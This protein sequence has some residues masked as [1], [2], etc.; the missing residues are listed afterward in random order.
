MKFDHLQTFCALVE[1]GSL[2]EAARRVHRTQPAISQHLRALESEFGL[3]LYERRAGRPTP[4]GATLYRRAKDLLHRGNDLRREMRAYDEGL[5]PLIV[6]ASDTNALYV[7]PEYIQ[8]F[9]K[10]HA[11][12]PLSIVCRPSAAIA[13]AV[14]NGEIDVGIVTLPVNTESL[15]HHRLDEHRLVLI[16]PKRH[17]L[18]VHK[19]ARATRLANETFVLLEPDTRTGTAIEAFLAHH[20]IAPAIAMRTG[21]FEVIKRYVAEGV[22]ISFVPERVLTKSDRNALAVVSVPGLPAIPIGAVWRATGYRPAG[23]ARFLNELGVKTA[24]T[25][26]DSPS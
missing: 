9:R 2:D 24:G 25:G 26:A 17:A 4:A 18:A 3:T 22:G 5:E 15:A 1:G 16:T 7:L 12:T 6:G 20:T 23:V 14:A 21:S 11:R 8:T 19:R 10:A 13:E